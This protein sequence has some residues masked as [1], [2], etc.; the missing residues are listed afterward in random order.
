M[1]DVQ[2]LIAAGSA[3]ILFLFGLEN[4]SREVER[5]S[6]ERFRAFLA[7]YTR[8]PLAG[9]VLGAGI[10]ATIQSSTATSV[11][12]VGLVNAGVISFA[13]SLGL[14]MGA[15]IGTCVTAQLI[16][17]KLTALAPMFI[18]FG[19]LLSSFRN[20]FAL[21]GKSIFYFGFVFFSLNLVSATL[22]PL[23]D[24]PRMLGMLGQDQ[25]ILFAVLAGAVF[26]A[27]VHS[28]SVTTGLAVV[29]TQ[30]G[31][32]S[33]NNAIPI[34]MGANIGTCVTAMLA[35]IKMERAAK[36]TALAHLFFNVGG[37]LM[38]IPLLPMI[39]NYVKDLTM[40]AGNIL[41]NVHLVFN[42]TTTAVFLL[43]LKPFTRFI[44]KITHSSEA[45]E[46]PELN[47][48]TVEN[49]EQLQL[50]QQEMR[51][52]RESLYTFVCETYNLTTL[53]I[54]TN[55]S[56]IFE[57][58]MK[59]RTHMKM[60]RSQC[61]RHFAE[62]MCCASDDDDSIKIMREV[63]RFDYIYQIDDSLEDM[64]QIKLNMEEMM[65]DLHP[66]VLLSIREVTTRTIRIMAHLGTFLQQ[67]DQEGNRPLG[68]QKLY[69]Q[70]KNELRELQSCLNQHTVELMT[71]ISSTSRSDVVSLAQFLNLSQRLRDKL[72]NF[73]KLVYVQ[74]HPD[75]GHS[76][77]LTQLRLDETQSGKS[78]K[79]MQELNK[80]DQMKD[81][82]D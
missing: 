28:S 63:K 24:D 60:L 29:L 20:R 16:A 50:A 74:R 37:V 36:R 53:S 34:I 32:L 39:N 42:I 82:D 33:L 26:S 64:L 17:F 76:R 80:T 6:G 23:Q 21:F 13:S 73:A 70:L 58:V 27:A 55:F 1:N 45:S 75:R 22:K 5:I 11:I 19:F 77:K 51:D 15:N 52:T 81:E 61:Y 65:I 31:I 72:Y 35:A 59:R 40:P 49:S 66:D 3:I 43:L 38:F 14:I 56:N 25:G 12:T 54:E 7:K 41:A 44:E 9:T 8:N 18:I 71:T 57:K 46:L 67:P 2:L 47:F 48:T 68:E 62:M 79:I 69:G 30:Q 10:T 78:L 4:F